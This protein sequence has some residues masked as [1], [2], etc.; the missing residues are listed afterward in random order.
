MAAL[1]ALRKR[2]IEPVV[3]RSS[4]AYLIGGHGSEDEPP[5]IVPE[6]CVIVVPTQMGRLTTGPEVQRNINALCSLSSYTIMNPLGNVK[7]IIQ[8]FGSVAIFKE[9]DKCPGFSYTLLG[10]SASPTC[11]YDFTKKGSRYSVKCPDLNVCRANFSGVMN[12]STDGRECLDT[13]T[14]NQ[15]SLH[16]YFQMN[17][18]PI[19][20]IFNK[21]VE[22]F[23]FLYGYSVYPTPERVRFA[24]KELTLVNLL[25]DYDEFLESPVCVLLRKQGVIDTGGKHLGPTL[26][27]TDSE[28]TQMGVTPLY[29]DCFKAFNLIRDTTKMNISDEALQLIIKFAHKSIYL[30]NRNYFNGESIIHVTQEELCYKL[31]GVYY[32]FVCRFKSDISPYIYKWNENNRSHMALNYNKIN[33]SG[34][35]LLRKNALHQFLRERVGEAEMYRKKYIRN[36]FYTWRCPEC[37][38][39]NKPDATVCLGCGMPRPTKAGGTRKRRTK[40]KRKR[41]RSRKGN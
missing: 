16:Y 19:N 30:E 14:F 39:I 41:T 2:K 1:E 26:E 12:V 22:Y 15:Y 18:T 8:A 20:T 29:I 13:I 31:P 28:L 10:C 27:I 34:P 23:G 3:P 9:G 21:V 25:D 36:A 5:F 38:T 40:E 35:G 7:K 24:V 17:P 37:G 4:A 11:E 33:L 6:G 32:N